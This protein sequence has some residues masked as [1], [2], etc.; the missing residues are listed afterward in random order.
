LLPWGRFN[1]GIFDILLI[2]AL[3]EHWRRRY[4]S[5]L[6]ALLP[7]VIGFLLIYGYVLVFGN[8]DLPLIP[9]ITAGWI[10]SEGVQQFV[11]HTIRQRIKSTPH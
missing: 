4:A 2:V 7:G 11:K 8:G 10:A 5:Y 3:A 1:I 9:F 6:I